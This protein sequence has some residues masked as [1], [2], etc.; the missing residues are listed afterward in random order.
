MF[1]YFDKTY[2]NHMVTIEMANLHKN[3]LGDVT[4]TSKFGF[5]IHFYPYK[6]LTQTFPQKHTNK[7]DL[8]RRLIALQYLVNFHP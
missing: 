8:S 3:R 2:K 5:G 6:K 1:I 4:K 7:M